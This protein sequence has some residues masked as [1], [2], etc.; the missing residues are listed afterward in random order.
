MAKPLLPDALWERIKPL[1][2]RE[3]PQAERRPARE[4]PIV[5]HSRGF[6]SY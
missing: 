4:F 1:L 3:R 5:R 6:S 2:P